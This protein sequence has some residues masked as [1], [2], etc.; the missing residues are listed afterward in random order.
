[1]DMEEMDQYTRGVSMNDVDEDRD[2]MEYGEYGDMEG[3]AM[4]MDDLMD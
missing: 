2:E 1:M 3:P 4:S